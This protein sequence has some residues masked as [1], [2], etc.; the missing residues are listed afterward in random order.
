MP[1][2]N[3]TSEIGALKRVV[4][5]SPGPEV[6]AMT[7][8]EA[9][10]DLYNDIIPLSAVRA[11]HDQ[12]KS[13]LSRV[14]K[15]HELKD[16]LAESLASPG[17]RFE[18]LTAMARLCPIEPIIDELTGLHPVDLAD[19]VIEGLPA[20]PSSLAGILSP[21]SFVMRPLPNAYFM[22]DSAAVFRDWAVSCATA[23]DVRL[24][25]SIVTRFVFTRH[26]E[27]RAKG[28]L[29]DGPRA[30]NRFVSIEGGDIL[31]VGPRVLAIGISERT[32][33]DAVEL[34][35]KN[36]GRAFE[37]PVTILAVVVPKERATIHLDMVFTMVDRDAALVYAPVVTGPNRAEVVRIDVDPHGRAS[38][39]ET[40]GLLPAL[41]ALGWDLEPILCGD[42]HHLYQDR[43]QWWSGAN[44]FAFAPGKIVMYSCNVRTLDALSRRGFAVKR[45][46]DFEDGREDPFA[47]GRLAV[48]FDGIELARGG[49]GARCMTLPVEREEL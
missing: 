34:L 32:S 43:E 44:S 8:K 6:E 22:R 47:P 14:A 5:H 23:F 36:A 1:G 20:K 10:E 18:F 2:L 40:D 3:V 37:E 42:G 25:E 15:V 9:A 33:P 46:V 31:V 35:A 12:L 11:E 21:R 49:G 45:A 29:V 26:P 38:Y 13:F 16:L 28:L 17:S 19:L 27:F 24:I 7:P 39:S 30:R 41:K 4:L 48:G